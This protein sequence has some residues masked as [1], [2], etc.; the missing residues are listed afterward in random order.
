MW[1]RRRFLHTGAASLLMAQ[2]SAH[3]PAMAATAAG[4]KLILLGTQGGPNVNIKRSEA[5][6][7]FVVDGVPYLV[8]CGYGALRAIVQSG[9]SMLD[10]GHVF[11]THLHDDHTA[12]LVALL[13]HLWTQ[14]RVKPT[15]VFGPWGTNS[16]VEAANHFNEINVEIRLV[17]EA[18]SLLPKDMFKGTVVPAGPKPVNVFSDDRVKVTAVENTH[19]PDESKAKIPHRSLSYRFDAKDRSVV[20]SGDTNYSDNLVAL[21]RGADVL[22]CEAMLIDQFRTNFDERVKKG[23]YADNPEGVWHHIISTHTTTADAGRMAQAAG[24]KTLVFTHVIPGANV[25]LPDKVYIEAAAAHFKGRIIVGKDQ[26][27]L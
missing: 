5:A 14:G 23:Y 8:D 27:V 13:S 12:D 26:M 3:L 7:L 2:V 15:E 19:Y 10:I 6:N 21:A 9:V 24:V 17:D 20:F 18:R 11:L 25:E 22:V 4:S 16:L 1:S